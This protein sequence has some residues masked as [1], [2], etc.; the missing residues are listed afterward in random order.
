MLGC[1]QLSALYYGYKTMDTELLFNTFIH[2]MLSSEN[3]IQVWAVVMLLTDLLGLVLTAIRR[4]G[5]ESLE[6]VV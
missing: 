2:L 1:Y 5:Y 4:R 3:T 6:I